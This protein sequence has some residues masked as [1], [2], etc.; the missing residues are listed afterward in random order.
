MTSQFRLTYIEAA[1]AT[2]ARRRPADKPW[3]THG[4]PT[5]GA[6]T[7]DHATRRVVSARQIS[8]AKTTPAE[9]PWVHDSRSDS[10]GIR[11]TRGATTADCATRRAVSARQIA[12]AKRPPL[13]K[14]WVHDSRPGSRGMATDATEHT[15]SSTAEEHSDRSCLLSEESEPKNAT[16]ARLSDRRI[17]HKDAV[18]KGLDR[19]SSIQTTT[20]EAA[21]PQAS[22]K[23]STAT[24]SLESKLMNQYNISYRAALRITN[25]ARSIATLSHNSVERICHDVINGVE[26]DFRTVKL[27]SVAE[28]DGKTSGFASRTQDTVKNDL[29]VMARKPTET[30]IVNRNQ[31]T[32]APAKP[33]VTRAR[34]VA[35][36]STVKPR[37]EALIN[38]V[39]PVFDSSPPSWL[40]FKKVEQVM[41][42][43]AKR[44]ADPDHNSGQSNLTKALVSS[45]VDNAGS[46]EMEKRDPINSADVGE[47]AKSFSR[48]TSPA[49]SMPGPNT[50]MEERGADFVTNHVPASDIVGYN[51]LPESMLMEVYHFRTSEA[52]KIVEEARIATGV[53]DWIP[54]TPLLLKECQRMAEFELTKRGPFHRTD[55]VELK[56]DTNCC[57]MQVPLKVEIEAETVLVSSKADESLAPERS[58]D[59]RE[60]LVTCESE[61]S[62]ESNRIE[63]STQR[64]WLVKS[65][66]ETSR[67]S[68]RI[69][70]CTQREL[71]VKSDSDTSREGAQS[72]SEASQEATCSEPSSQTELSIKSE[73]ETS[74]KATQ[75][76]SS[77]QSK[78]EEML[79][80]QS[81]PSEPSIP[82]MRMRSLICPNEMAR[83]LETVLAQR[84]NISW[85]EAQSLVRKGR[86]VLDMMQGNAWTPELE[87]LCEDTYVSECGEETLLDKNDKA[88][89]VARSDT[90]S[91]VYSIDVKDLSIG[92]TE[93]G[94]SWVSHSLDDC[95]LVSRCPS[96][97]TDIVFVEDDTGSFPSAVSSTASL[98]SE[99][100]DVPCLI[101][102]RM[103]ETPEVPADEP[104]EAILGIPVLRGQRVRPT[105]RSKHDG[106]TDS[107]NR[108][109]GPRMSMLRRT[110]AK[111][112]T[113]VTGRLTDNCS[114]CYKETLV[115]L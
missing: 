42:V 67:D 108:F 47:C 58:L 90:M 1:E 55:Q 3:A 76:E 38:E 63:P 10:R 61:T 94:K 101:F 105:I 33:A 4:R 104:L 44:Q 83:P 24:V 65:D 77:T 115:N 71:L 23:V 113:K 102:V 48:S 100:F 85:Q 13:D 69:G 17:T 9:K 56:T 53:T 87:R 46:E 89:A 62:R 6:T 19:W 26:S 57:A 31:V 64:E 84:H 51:V 95:S 32:A 14:P 106:S 79:A 15:A 93:I 29:L 7:A 35:G 52:S 109:D 99:A 30:K 12:I 73:S 20:A 21:L 27:R 28:Q 91:A 88:N 43:P 110:F 68:D 72:E 80:T 66:S 40:E 78:P 74:Q 16:V 114:E 25:K 36:S 49:D 34:V 107:S 11:P 41:P 112:R 86:V 22:P 39:Q 60:R 103:D 97:T 70:L 111:I 98:R 37:N 45:S 18:H 92:E 50:Q 75:I 2:A 59:Q 81:L 8:I 5:R 82:L 96:R 54:C